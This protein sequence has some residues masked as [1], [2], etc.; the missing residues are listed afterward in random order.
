MK[1]RLAHVDANGMMHDV[2]KIKG[3]RKREKEEKKK[4]GSS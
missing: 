3:K 2:L 1:G 4:R